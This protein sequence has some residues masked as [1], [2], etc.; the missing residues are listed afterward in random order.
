VCLF[1]RIYAA[2]PAA[3]ATENA[4]ASSS[5]HFQQEGKKSLL[6]PKGLVS[7]SFSSKVN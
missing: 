5:E 7:G 1:G 2:A 4:K 3:A 6:N